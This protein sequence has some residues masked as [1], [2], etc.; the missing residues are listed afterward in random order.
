MMV[1]LTEKADRNFPPKP[2][3]SLLTHASTNHRI[4]GAMGHDSLSSPI[5][6]EDLEWDWHL[7]ELT[8]AGE[9]LRDQQQQSTLKS[10][11]T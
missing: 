10:Q 5:N 6:T 3:E 7:F 8:I 9:E 4:E 2:K 1:D 11:T